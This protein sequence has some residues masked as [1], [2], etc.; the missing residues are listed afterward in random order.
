MLQHYL[1]NPYIDSKSFHIESITILVVK[2]ASPTVI[3]FGATGASGSIAAITAE[4]LGAKVI[5]ALRDTSKPIPGL[6]K[7]AEEE[8]K[9]QRVQADLNQPDSVL[10]AVTSTKAE[11]AFIYRV[12]GQPDNSRESIEALKSGGI[13]EVVFLSSSGIRGRAQ[14]VSPAAFIPYAHAQV[15]QALEEVFGAEGYYALRP[16]FFASNNLD[17]V[18]A[19]RSGEVKVHSYDA[20]IDCIT[21]EDIGRVAG[22]ILV[23]GTL[24]NERIIYLYGPQTYTGCQVVQAMAKKMGKNPKILPATWEEIY[25]NIVQVRKFPPPIAKFLADHSNVYKSGFGQLQVLGEA[26]SEDQLGNVKKYSGVKAI[27]LDEW[28]EKNKHV[29]N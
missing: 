18:G 22:T 25:D 14:D 16:G 24:D 12:H 26:I 11:K 4:S 10:N 13:K 29:W 20:Y 28:L 8:G 27:T 9:Y 15:E 7:E 2:M 19:I 5:L 21:Q 3:V 23:R 17:Y 1:L 6:T